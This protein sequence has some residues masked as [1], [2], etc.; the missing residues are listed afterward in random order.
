MIQNSFNMYASNKAQH[1]IILS[2]RFNT[3]GV[4]AI[5]AHWGIPGM[6]YENTTSSS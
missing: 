3:N 1:L 4:T 2:G 6:E 5:A